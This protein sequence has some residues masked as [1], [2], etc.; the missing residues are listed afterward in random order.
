MGYGMYLRLSGVWRRS[1][2]CVCGYRLGCDPSLCHYGR[3]RPVWLT[4]YERAEILG[5]M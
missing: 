4:P 5:N 1:A 3:E 2:T